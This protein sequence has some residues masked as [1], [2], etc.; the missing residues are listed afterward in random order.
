MAQHEYEA[1]FLEIDVQATVGAL[2]AAGAEQVFPK[3]M[4][5]RLIFENDAV[6]GE[7]WLRLR[8]EGGRTTLT[9]KQVTDATH[10]NGTTEIEIEVDD[11]AKTAEL[12]SA[13]GL[14]QVRYQQ[15]YREE[16]QLDGVTYDFD[17][18]PDLDTFLEIEGPSEAAVL[19]AVAA[20]GLDYDHAR[21]GSVDLIYKSEL[22]RDILAEPTLLFR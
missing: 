7:Q 16:W 6:Q 8:D 1:K 4:F 9:L 22:G 15:N 11:L 18:W 20:L 17:T 2:R 3:T 21:F 12:L 19:D 13:L 10:I 5:T 14:R